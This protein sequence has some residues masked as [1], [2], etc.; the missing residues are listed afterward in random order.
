VAGLDVERGVVMLAEMTGFVERGDAP[1]IVTAIRRGDDIEINTIGAMAFGGPAVG[2]DTIFRIASM[3]K[4]IAAV[5]AMTLVEAGVIGLDQPVDGL[6]PELADR[7]VLRD[8]AGPL[9]DTVPAERAITLR[10]LLTFRMGFGMTMSLP[11][12]API[13]AAAAEREVG[14][15]P[16]KTAAPLTPDEWLARFGR[17]PL[18]FQPG[19]TW[20]YQTSATVLGILIARASGRSLADCLEERVFAPLGMRD[21]GFSVPEDKRDRFATQYAVDPAT[22]T[23][24]VADD[25]ADSKWAKPWPSPDAGADLVSTIDDY[26]A[27]ARM[28]AGGGTGVLTPESVALI[29]TDHLDAGQT[30][31]DPAVGWGFGLSVVRS[32]EHVGRYGWNGGLGTVWFN[33]PAEDL[34]AILLTQR[35]W[36]SPIPPEVVEAFTRSAYA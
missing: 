25:P 33:D 4:P 3:T 21:T 29:T 36:E 13:L 19:S 27:F 30:T 2:R 1:G 17:L 32:G 15:G 20:A 23:L 14:V 10:D 5:A 12:T 18:M 7:R 24:V 8:P 11:F 34:I 26:L 6:L 22:R 16:P 28:M 9:D 31:F 35:M